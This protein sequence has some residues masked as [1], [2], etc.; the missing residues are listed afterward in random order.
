MSM[1]ERIFS[2]NYA[3]NLFISLVLSVS[4]FAYLDIRDG[5]PDGYTSE[6]HQYE[7]KFKIALII[8]GLCLINLNMFLLRR[9]IDSR[10]RVLKY[11]YALYGVVLMAMVVYL[12]HMYD[13]MDHGQGG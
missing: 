4:V 5:F 2:F 13:L 6:Y 7:N 3:L 8:L 10:K 9:P 12:N 11:S 1:I